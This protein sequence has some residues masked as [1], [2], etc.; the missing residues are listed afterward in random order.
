M[1]CSIQMRG[2]LSIFLLY[3]LESHP[4]LFQRRSQG[5]ESPSETP[6][7]G[8]AVL[9]SSERLLETEICPGVVIHT[10]ELSNGKTEAGNLW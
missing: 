10:C 5:L 8:A 7:I 4:K 2:P 3:F 9:A 6:V 1:C